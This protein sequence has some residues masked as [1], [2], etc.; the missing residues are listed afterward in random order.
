MV[1]LLL[2]CVA[3]DPAK[4]GPSEPDPEPDTAADTAAD[5]DTDSDSAEGARRYF[6]DG[7]RW[8]TD[9]SDAPTDPESAAI[10]GFLQREGW[11]NDRFQVDFSMEV[12]DAGAA[13]E[14]REFVPTSDFYS[15]DCDHVPVPIPEGGALE[16]EEGYACAGNGDCHLLVAEWDEGRLYEMWRADLRKDQFRGGCLAVWDMGRVYPP[17]GRGD[18]CTSADAAGYPIAPLIFDADEVAAGEVA[19]AIRFILPNPEIR[20][21][22]FVHPATHSTGSASG[23]AEAPPYGAQLRLRADFP[24]DSL[25]NEGARVVARGL[26][27]YG[28]FLADGGTVALTA[29]S[30]RYTE[31][32][33]EGLL[34]PHDLEAIEPQDFEVLEMDEPIPLT[35][36]CQR[37]PKG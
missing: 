7:A 33:W 22:E 10:I 32:K 20:A 13:T 11:G 24:L 26:Q 4:G 21:A 15:P 31:A 36:D 8:Y 2:A 18:Q 3:A 25:P 29:R 19:H 37:T 17:E 6:P 30:D 23:P 9:V 1:H 35:Y 5:T 16:G 28:M 34:G 14:R 27:R 12:L